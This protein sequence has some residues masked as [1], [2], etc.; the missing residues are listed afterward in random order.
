MHRAK[1][2]ALALPFLALLGLTGASPTGA[3]AG[4]AAEAGT[5]ASQADAI[6][7]VLEPLIRVR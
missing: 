1:A 5:A 7:N 3:L 4:T 6:L 2:R